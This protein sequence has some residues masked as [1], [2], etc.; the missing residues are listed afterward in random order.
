MEERK[1]EGEGRG[2]RGRNYIAVR[3]EGSTDGTAGAPT[4]S[5]IGHSRAEKC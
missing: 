5:A 4:A 1:E 2:R 3:M